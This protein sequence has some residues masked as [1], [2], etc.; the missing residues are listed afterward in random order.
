MG[1]GGASDGARS[2]KVARGGLDVRR[3]GT[4]LGAVVENATATGRLAPGLRGAVIIPAHDEAAVIG[5]TLTALSPL[6]ALPGVEI[7]VV[8]NGCRDDTASIARGFV[9]VTVIEVERGSKT[10]ALN[11]GD[12]VAREWP[13]LYLDADVSMAPTA[14]LALFTALADPG[15]LAVRAYYAYDIA[16]ATWPVRAYYRAR[17]R[18]TA[19]A[20]RLWGAGGYALSAHGHAR[21]AR[22]PE[23]TA[24]DSWVDELFAEQEKRAVATVP[25]IVRTPRTAP[26]LLSVLT[27]QRR[28]C[29][30]LGTPAR[31]A[32]RLVAL[33]AS[34]R[35]PVS[36]IDA[37]CYVLLTLVARRRAAGI[38]RRGGAV[39]ERDGSSRVDPVRV[40]CARTAS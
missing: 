37:A 6:T 5:R 9:G 14:V 26:A 8:A 13:R 33:A 29:E 30:E 23:V 40:D 10:L 11:T 7:I 24:D 1:C 12:A 18:I 21:F 35:G 3:D 25:A 20:N 34:V 36:A 19:P 39:W 31:P 17:A 22:F 4:I 27:R 32:P 16:G 28:G 15:T 2:G 38:A